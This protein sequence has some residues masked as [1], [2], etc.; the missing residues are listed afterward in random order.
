MSVKINTVTATPAILNSAS[1]EQ[2]VTIKW[3]ATMAAAS[4]NPVNI[5]LII[6]D[7]ND[8]VYF[9]SDKNSNEKAIAWDRDLKLGDNDYNKI[10]VMIVT[11]AQSENQKTK[12]KIVSTGADGVPSTQRFTLTYK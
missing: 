10:V 11:K 6:N 5:A 1:G 4:D 12:L 2:N 8:P 7:E 9:V 3:N